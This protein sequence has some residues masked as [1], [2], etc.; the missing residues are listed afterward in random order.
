LRLHFLQTIR[1]NYLCTRI[2]ICLVKILQIHVRKIIEKQEQHYIQQ[3]YL[4]GFSPNY[5]TSDQKWE[6]EQIFVLNKKYDTITLTT[7]KKV[8]YRK[9]YYSFYNKEN[10]LDSKIEDIFSIVEDKFIKFRDKLRE[11]INQ[12]NLTGRVFELESHYR[13]N[14]CEYIKMNLIRIPKVMDWIYEATRIHGQYISQKYGVEFDEKHYKNLSLRAMLSMFNVKGK[15][16][17]EHLFERDISFEYFGRTKGSLVTSDN[18]VIMVNKSNPPG[19]AYFDTNIIF[20]IDQNKY[21]RFVKLGGKDKYIR[22]QEFNNINILNL[23]QYKNAIK[24]VYGPSEEVLL[25]LS[26]NKDKT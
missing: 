3:A 18:P 6:K 26:K 7:I 20:P 22:L 2:L 19:L 16:L 14:I 10:L 17:S 5:F 4:K 23:L 15:D 8:A 11:I 9:N 12:I 24:E 13:T 1:A 21:M 25:K